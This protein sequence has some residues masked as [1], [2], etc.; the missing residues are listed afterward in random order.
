[1]KG[2]I[3]SDYAQS[4]S[5]FGKPIKLPKSQGWILK[6]KIPDEPFYDAMGC[7][8]LFCCKNWSELHYDLE[9][10]VGDDIVSLSIVTD[11]F[12]DFDEGYLKNCFS[13]VCIPFKEHFVVNLDNSLNSI[14]SKHHRKKSLKALKEIKVERCKDPIEILDEWVS[15]YSILVDKHK[16]KGL[17]A[18]SSYAFKKQLKVP[19]IVVFKGLFNDEL[20]GIQ[21]WY[22]HGKIAYTHLSAYSTKGYTLSASY[23]IRWYSIEYF[24]DNNLDWLNLGA[25][26]GLNK[27]G[28]NGLTK[29]KEGWSTDK[30]IAY[31]C[32]R[33]FDKSLYNKIIDEKNIRKT[34]YF[35]AYRDGEF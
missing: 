18:F 23:A 6:R 13:D 15:L 24:K 26:A 14:I 32:G 4:L 35:P 29:F 31:F 7:Y 1:M 34:S 30:K 22:N 20:V 8:P 5:E 25:G 21:L 17:R 3:S 33:I 9:N 16:I 10:N 12:G 2:Y 19:G 28:R 11:P 27:N